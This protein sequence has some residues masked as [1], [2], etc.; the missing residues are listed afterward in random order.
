MGIRPWGRQYHNHEGSGDSEATVW[1]T[2][3]RMHHLYRKLLCDVLR[4]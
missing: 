1:H 2:K 3:K 4:H